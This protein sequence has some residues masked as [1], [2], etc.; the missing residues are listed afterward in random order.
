MRLE[1]LQGWEQKKGMNKLVI[2]DSENCLPGADFT[3]LEHEEAQKLIKEHTKR[4]ICAVVNPDT[5]SFVNG[6]IQYLHLP[7]A[8]ALR[9]G[10]DLHPGDLVLFVEAERTKDNGIIKELYHWKKAEVRTGARMPKA[11]TEVR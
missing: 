8:V 1:A 6:F 3:V 10:F 9:S 4:T 11:F 2:V 7:Q 5:R